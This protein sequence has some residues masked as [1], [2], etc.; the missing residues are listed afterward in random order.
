MTKRIDIEPVSRIE[1]LG[2]IV[3]IL[4]DNGQVEEARLQMNELKGFEKFCQ[5]RMLWEMP[6]IV[7]RICGICSVS[8]HLA[9]V[10]ACEDLIDAKIPP[11]ALKL[12]ELLNLAQ[13]IY[14][15]SAHFYFLAA[16][17]FLL[18]TKDINPSERSFIGLMK[19]QPL[20][21]E[22]AIE[23]RR[24]SS[25]IMKKVGGR[26]I[27]PVSVI[28]GGM[29]KPMT[30]EERFDLSKEVKKGLKLAE[31]TFETSWK[32]IQEFTKHQGFLTDNSSIQAAISND[33]QLEFYQGQIKFIDPDNK[34]L[35]QFETSNYLNYLGEKVVDWSYHKIPF[36]LEKGFP[37]GTYLSGPLARLNIAQD[38]PTEKASTALIEFKSL[39][40]GGSVQAKVYQH[41]AR[42]IEVLYA[43]ERA[44]ILLEDDQIVSNKVRNAIKRKGGEGIGVVE[45]PRGLL[46][47]HYWADSVGRIKK[48]NLIVATAHNSYQM[49]RSIN[50]AAQECIDNGEITDEAANHIKMVTRCY[51][52]CLTCATHSLADNNSLSIELIDSKGRIVNVYGG[53]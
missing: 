12:R 21:M 22:K 20:L 8:H 29:S 3:L 10:K 39:G 4:D 51:D 45:A 15:H 13:L 6:L 46:I 16:A 24:I 28:P 40:Q 34:L 49:N 32:I 7:T 19:T 9:S 38:I 37:E 52:P 36:L 1:G 17:D 30:H 43:F 35:Y 48:I 44:L 42:F 33:G 26:I 5:G 27:H 53:K 47:H 18:L 23:M 2:K 41:Y 11:A 14:S 31:E 25:E 50:S